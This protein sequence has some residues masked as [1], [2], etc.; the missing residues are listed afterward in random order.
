MEQGLP[1]S[2]LPA[3]DTVEDL[4]GAA[5]QTSVPLRLPAPPLPDIKTAEHELHQGQEHNNMNNS[6]HYI[7][8]QDC[9]SDEIDNKAN[10]FPPSRNPERARSETSATTPTP[11]GASIADFVAQREKQD[12]GED[13]YSTTG[14][15]VVKIEPIDVDF[16]ENDVSPKKNYNM[17][18]LG[19]KN[20]S[21][22]E[23]G[24]RWVSVV[25]VDE[26]SGSSN[27]PVAGANATT[28][29]MKLEEG[30]VQQTAESDSGVGSKEVLMTSG[31]RSEEPGAQEHHL[32]ETTNRGYGQEVHQ[33]DVQFSRPDDHDGS[34]KIKNTERSSSSPDYEKDYTSCEDTKSCVLPTAEMFNKPASS[35]PSSAKTIAATSGTGSGSTF[36][37]AEDAAWSALTAPAAPG[38]GATA[39]PVVPGENESKPVEELQVINKPKN[40]PTRTTSNKPPASTT[41]TANVNTISLRETALLF[42]RLLFQSKANTKTST[43]SADN[44]G[45]GGSSSAE[46]Q[47]EVASNL[48]G[49]QRSVGE[50]SISIRG[51]AGGSALVQ[52]K[53]EEKNEHQ[54]VGVDRHECKTGGSA[55]GNNAPSQSA[56]RAKSPDDRAL[57]RSSSRASDRTSR[58]RSSILST[59]RSRTTSRSSSSRGSQKQNEA[60][61]TQTSPRTNSRRSIP[62]LATQQAAS[63][64][65]T[66]GNNCNSEQGQLLQMHVEDQELQSR[67]LSGVS[68]DENNAFSSLRTTEN[69]EKKNNQTKDRQKELHRGL[70][71]TTSRTRRRTCSRE[72]SWTRSLSTSRSCSSS[73]DNYHGSSSSSSRE[74]QNYRRRSRSRDRYRFSTNRRGHQHRSRSQNATSARR[75][76]REESGNG[77]H[78][79]P[80]SR[81]TKTKT[82]N[83][84]SRHF[85]K[86]KDAA[87]KLQKTNDGANKKQTIKNGKNSRGNNRNNRRKK[88]KK[89][90]NRN[91]IML[92]NTTDDTSAPDQQNL[93][94]P[95]INK[96]NTNTTSKQTLKSP[97]QILLRL[98]TTA[99]NIEPAVKATRSSFSSN[100][101]AEE[102]LR[103]N[104]PKQFC[105]QLCTRVEA[106]AALR[107][108]NEG[109]QGTSRSSGTNSSRVDVFER[110]LAQVGKNADFFDEVFRSVNWVL[111]SKK[112]EEEGK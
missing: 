62:G 91:N 99:T 85:T 8:L 88:G 53:T 75:G 31:Q 11:G 37:T 92:K 94:R 56:S 4:S 67:N 65:A 16:F 10:Y 15:N 63:T 7:Q 86:G 72:R 70:H 57:S 25:S 103:K 38:L 20:P 110:L 107:N 33:L 111:V 26:Q 34:R 19:K 54:A 87:P 41:S 58:S 44:C 83:Y 6:T 68:L 51:P 30:D 2:P 36:L 48:C 66:T 73:Y 90:N 1:L 95:H 23:N 21:W 60:M 18:V 12:H 79:H 64:P 50:S 35:S 105:E 42:G 108:E 76:G 71:Y 14:T 93:L 112:K 52:E 28:E 69:E 102:W 55:V 5:P 43:A 24:F 100:K 22:D 49:D 84:Q 40:T 74:H 106:K 61:V 104:V 47:K 29:E 81:Q 59:S 13:K 9:C 27:T 82:N 46:G 77:K 101:T 17:T 97:A 78:K 80:R 3:T 39:V 109:E 32:L 96:M 98:L 89:N 45:K